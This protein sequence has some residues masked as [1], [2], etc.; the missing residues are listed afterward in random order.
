[1]QLSRCESI[2]AQPDLVEG[3]RLLST[4]IRD[5]TGPLY[6]WQYYREGG[7]I[8]VISRKMA[9]VDPNR[10]AELALEA[11]SRVVGMKGSCEN[12]KDRIQIVVMYMRQDNNESGGICASVEAQSA[13]LTLTDVMKHEEDVFILG[14]LQKARVIIDDARSICERNGT[15]LPPGPPQIRYLNPRPGR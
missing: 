4:V 15:L 3:K 1:M 12:T 14:N 7:K 10:P 8:K 11:L 9:S 2:R 13:L 6:Y 5:K